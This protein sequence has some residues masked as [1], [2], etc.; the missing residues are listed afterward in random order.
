V[1]YLDLIPDCMTERTYSDEELF[2]LLR[3]WRNQ[4]L[5]ASDW[6]QLPDIDPSRV[7]VL[8]WRQY[9]QELR[10][11]FRQADDPKQIVFPATPS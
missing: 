5:A 3:L 1:N 4:Q 9:R 10:D 6:T 11:M 8:A 2:A 7:D